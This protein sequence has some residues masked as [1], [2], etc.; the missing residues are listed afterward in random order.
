MCPEYRIQIPMH[1][2]KQ[3]VVEKI[4]PNPCPK[5]KGVVVCVERLPGKVPWTKL[6]KKFFYS[7]LKKC[8]KCNAIWLDP[9]SIV[10]IEEYDNWL[11]SPTLSLFEV[12]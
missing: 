5:C 2:V 8:R 4:L 1:K 7:R 3:T 11:K 12:T 9:T 10:R 6:K